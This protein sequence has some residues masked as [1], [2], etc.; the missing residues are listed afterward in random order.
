[1][2]FNVPLKFYFGICSPFLFIYFLFLNMWTSPEN[3]ALYG[4]PEVGLHP[5]DSFQV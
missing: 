1:M 4:K 3:V 5:K 2:I